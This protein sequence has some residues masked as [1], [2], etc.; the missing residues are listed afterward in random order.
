[1]PTF[2]KGF[3]N[4]LGLSGFSLEHSWENVHSSQ[5]CFKFAWR[6]DNDYLAELN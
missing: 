1:M 2:A 3:C 6:L 4:P 5:K